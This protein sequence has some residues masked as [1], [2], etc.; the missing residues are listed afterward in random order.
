LQHF[1]PYFD[2]VD[3]NWEQV[4]S[5]SLLAAMKAEN[6]KEYADVIQAMLVELQDGHASLVKPS[7]QAYPPFRLAW[8][9]NRLMIRYVSQDAPHGLRSG[10]LVISIDHHSAT[11]LLMKAMEQLSGTEQY[12]RQVALD[13]ILLGN[14]NQ[15]MLI[16]V[17]TPDGERKEFSLKRTEQYFSLEKIATI[18]AT[19]ELEAGIFYVD[20][21]RVD[22]PMFQRILPELQSASGIV[23]DLRGYP[24]P[25]AR[26]VLPHLLIEPVKSQQFLIPITT[27][28]DRKRVRFEDVSQSLAP[29]EPYL[30]ARKIFLID[31]NSISY[32]ETLLSIVAY[33]QL[34]ELVGEPTAGANGNS[35]ATRLPLNLTFYWTGMKVLS[36]DGTQFHTIGVQPN[37]L[38]SQ[39]WQGII[40]GQDEQLEAA[41]E[42]LRP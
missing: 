31:A 12:R 42:L 19:T 16:E 4:L 23:L 8:V 37:I 11:D 10:D 25:Y 7:G 39:S 22:E 29:Q 9:E 26:Y 41:L 13:Q 36:H 2:V 20:L 38:V 33:Y 17:E 27:W 14:S 34:A 30:S 32:S 6:D 18:P 1:Y 24:T 40:H 28:P 35:N 3:T 5:D 21:R 15:I